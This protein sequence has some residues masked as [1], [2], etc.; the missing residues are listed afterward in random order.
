MKTVLLTTALCVFTTFSAAAQDS[1]PAGEQ[2]GFLGE[3]S[4]TV[5]LVSDYVFRGIPS[6]MKMQLCRV[7]SIIAYR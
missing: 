4:G 5:G 3:F 2:G 1:A 7:R 6:R